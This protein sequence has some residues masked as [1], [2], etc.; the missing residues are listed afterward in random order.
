MCVNTH[1]GH[2]W[3]LS[4]SHSY[5]HWVLQWFA[6]TYGQVLHCSA[7]YLWRTTNN[8]S[9]PVAISALNFTIKFFDSVRAQR[10]MNVTRTRT[11]PTSPLQV[12]RSEFSTLNIIKRKWCR[13]VLDTHN[14]EIYL[15]S[16]ISV[17]RHRRMV[18]LFTP[19]WSHRPLIS[20][21]D[22][23]S[24]WWMVVLDNSVID[25]AI[26]SLL[27]DPSLLCKYYQ[28]TNVSIWLARVFLG[29]FFFLHLLLL[30][31]ARYMAKKYWTLKNENDG[32][33]KL[34]GLTYIC[35]LQSFSSKVN[36]LINFACQSMSSAS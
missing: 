31:S 24:V 10:Y 27:H 2:R 11:V 26:H 20:I 1:T 25:L 36:D 7:H 5:T 22:L 21:H 29:C 30:L 4:L 16:I 15:W 32:E 18:G 17:Y 19:F 28:S 23:A 35:T 12:Y 34:S 9:L 33:V 3:S 14:P 8:S 6:S 13:N